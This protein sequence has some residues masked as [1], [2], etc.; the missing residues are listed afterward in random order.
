MR[1]APNWRNFR[2]PP[3]LVGVDRHYNS[4]RLSDA[5][6]DNPIEQARSGRTV[7]ERPE[8]S[9]EIDDRAIDRGVPVPL[10]L[11]VWHEFVRPWVEG[12][13]GRPMTRE[14]LTEPTMTT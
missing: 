5:V 11:D 14:W 12:Y 4:W 7:E 6:V 13:A 3:P 8:S 10:L 1:R 2:R 9:R